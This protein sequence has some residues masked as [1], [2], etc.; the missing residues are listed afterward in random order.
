MLAE[1][2]T[3]TVTKP[4]IVSC[5]NY[6]LNLN[7]CLRFSENSLNFSLC[8]TT[9]F[10]KW[11]YIDRNSVNFH[12][13]SETLTVSILECTIHKLTSRHE[14]RELHSRIKMGSK[15]MLFKKLKGQRELWKITGISQMYF[16]VYARLQWVLPPEYAVQCLR[17]STKKAR[18]SEACAL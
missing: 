10:L 5:L 14:L 2:S 8:S 9:E 15:G 13:I 3:D 11:C 4:C 7:L 6:T 1:K 18:L 17:L 12:C 16:G